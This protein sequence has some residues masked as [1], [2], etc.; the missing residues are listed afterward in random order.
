MIVIK[1][2]SRYCDDIYS[3]VA[4]NGV[5]TAVS[6][7][8]RVTVEYA[9]EVTLPVSRMRQILGRTTMFEC[10]VN[11]Y[12]VG[13]TYW[14]RYGEKISILEEASGFSTDAYNVEGNT[15][16][17]TL[18]IHKVRSIDYGKYECYSNN[19]LGSDSETLEFYRKFY[20]LKTFFRVFYFLTLLYRIIKHP[21]H[22]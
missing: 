9:P 14:R 22:S 21:V 1:N 20:R 12:P 7:Q 13:E 15:W 10:R 11:A 5:A 16:V 6:R 17:V 3:C 2:I 19:L 4:D 8:M 18:T